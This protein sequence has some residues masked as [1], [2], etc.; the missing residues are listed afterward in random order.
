MTVVITSCWW[1]ECGVMVAKTSTAR[2]LF[3]GDAGIRLQFPSAFLPS[4]PLPYHGP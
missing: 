3:H 1:R 2:S 4:N